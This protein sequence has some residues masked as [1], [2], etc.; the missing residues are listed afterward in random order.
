[1][2][3]DRLYAHLEHLRHEAREA[4]RF[5]DGMDKDTFL[6]NS[7]VQHAVGMCLVNIGEATTRIMDRHSGFA[8]AHPEIPWQDIRKLRNRVAHGYHDINFNIVWI[9]IQRDI[10]ALLE[11]LPLP[12]ES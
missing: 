8:A 9:L 7:L 1:M 2:T 4:M 11:K 5:V 12:P 10:P 6:T 3:D